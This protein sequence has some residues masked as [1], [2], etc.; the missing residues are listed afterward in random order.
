M[1]MEKDGISFILP[2]ILIFSVIT[3]SGCSGQEQDQNQ[4]IAPTDLA[5]VPYDFE[6]CTVDDPCAVQVAD[7]FGGTEPYTFQSDSFAT[8]APPM[9]MTIGMDGYL[10]GTPSLEG[11]YNFGVCVKDATSTSKCTQTTVI[12]YPKEEIVENNPPANVPANPPVNNPPANNPP[13]ATPDNEETAVVTL[14]SAAC[15]LVS[16][17]EIPLGGVRQGTS[18]TEYTFRVTASGTVKGPV[19][20]GIQLSYSP[21]E[22]T[23]ISDTDGVLST[24]SWT[25]GLNTRISTLH[26]IRRAAGE[27]AATNWQLDGGQYVVQSD[28]DW[29]LFEGATFY[30]TAKAVY[31]NSYGSYIQSTAQSNAIT[32]PA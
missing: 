24:T 19:G 16:K 12:V 2:L 23:L 31:T 21:D 13:Q 25:G 26:T 1:N 11:N 27:P 4:T 7:A 8:G 32:C 3:I 22:E 15:T 6:Q 5:I 10:S 14:D 30:I 29:S 9:G 28:P 17:R 18:I 20:A